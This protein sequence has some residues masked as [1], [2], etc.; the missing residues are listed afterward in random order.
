M[1]MYRT[2]DAL[3]VSASVAAENTFTTGLL[4]ALNQACSISI[5]G[6]FSGTVRLQRSFDNSTWENITNGDGT[7]LGWPAPCAP[8][9]YVAEERCFVRLGIPTGLYTSGTAVCRLGRG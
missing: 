8:G 2:A 1:P 7:A 6:T 9:A 4:L 5:S 3:A